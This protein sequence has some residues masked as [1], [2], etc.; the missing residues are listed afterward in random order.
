MLNTERTRVRM[1]RS[2]DGLVEGDQ[3]NLP[4]AT[5]RNLVNQGAA[6]TVPAPGPT[7]NKA[8]PAAPQNKALPPN[9]PHR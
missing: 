4:A 1:L 3:V 7:Q 2:V 6:A 5:A 9:K 8:I